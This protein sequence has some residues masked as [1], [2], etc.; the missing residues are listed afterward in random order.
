MW[1]VDT[2]RYNVATILN[3]SYRKNKNNNPVANARFDEM[4]N[5][6]I[7]STV[8]VQAIFSLLGA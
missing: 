4:F 3:K 5:V 8:L 6:P 2:Q 1:F 7:K